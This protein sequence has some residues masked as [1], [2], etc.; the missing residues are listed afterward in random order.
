MS[1]CACCTG[2][3]F[4]SRK[5]SAAMVHFPSSQRDAA[6]KIFISAEHEKSGFGRDS[7]GRF[8]FRTKKDWARS[9]H[10]LFQM[11]NG[12]RGNLGPL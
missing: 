7:P 10:D 3:Q 8:C 1:F 4:D 9:E 2:E 5:P 12:S 11:S 6:E